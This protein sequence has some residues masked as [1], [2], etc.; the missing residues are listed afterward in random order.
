[1][2]DHW[3]LCL[4][5]DEVLLQLGYL[6]FR[7]LVLESSLVSVAECASSSSAPSSV[8]GK[9]RQH[10]RKCDHPKAASGPEAD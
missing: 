4:Y 7:P 5:F 9:Y 1:M 2:Y 10:S 8:R 3:L 6:F